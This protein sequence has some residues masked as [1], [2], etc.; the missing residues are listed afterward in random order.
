[1][2]ASFLVS[3]DFRLSVGMEYNFAVALASA[4]ISILMVVVPYRANAVDF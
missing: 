1:M 2:L 4:V 3:V